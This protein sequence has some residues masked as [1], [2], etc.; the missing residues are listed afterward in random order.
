MR[1]I[2][3][4]VHGFNVKDEGEETIDTMTPYLIDDGYEVVNFDYDWTGVLRVRLCNGNLA[5]ALASM[6][7]HLIHVVAIG[8]SNG[9]AIIHEAC[10]SVNHAI[11]EVVYINPALNKNAELG[12]LVRQ[13]HVWYSPSD[14]PVKVSRWLIKHSWGEMGAT[15]YIGVDRRYKNYNKETG[16][17]I[18]SA[19][20]SDV[21]EPEKIEFFG[22]EIVSKLT[23][24]T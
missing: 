16:Y 19:S 24:L 8:H 14:K 15:G 17:K 1:K 22:P 11:R 23:K 4:L 6:S 13:A 12:K 2:A 5:T 7:K 10:Q 9:C 3:I 20:H 21:F 18:C